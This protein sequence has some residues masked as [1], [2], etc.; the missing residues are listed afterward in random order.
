MIKMAV[1]QCQ[2]VMAKITVAVVSGS[3]DK[4]DGRCSDRK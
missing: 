1:P 2:K 4:D 3:N